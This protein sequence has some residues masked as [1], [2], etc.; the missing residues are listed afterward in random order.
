MKLH[1]VQVMVQTTDKIHIYLFYKFKSPYNE[2]SYEGSS[3]AVLSIKEWNN[4]DIS[5]ETKKMIEANLCEDHGYASVELLID[6][7]EPSNG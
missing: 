7:P 1:D 2:Q 6:E 3:G 5:A 4:G